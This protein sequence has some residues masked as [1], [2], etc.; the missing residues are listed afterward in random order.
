MN[1]V[2]TAVLLAGMT[3]LF[4]GVGYSLGGQGG[5]LI[6]LLFA[7]ATNLWAWWGSDKAVLRMHGA[8]PVLPGDHYGLYEMVDLLSKNAGLPTPKV[9]LMNTD[10]PNAFATGRN[11][12][13]AAVAVTAGL[14]RT[15]NKE[16]VAGVVAH[17]LA[18]VQNRDTLIMTITATIAGAVSMIARFGMMFGGRGDSQ[19]SNPI[20][21]ILTMIAAPLAAMI[22]QMFVSRT[23]EYAADRRGAEICGNPLWL[24]SALQGISRGVQQRPM[25]SAENDPA[26]A[27]MFIINPL[28]GARLDN[29]FSTHP[30]TENRVAELEKMAGAMGA[31]LAPRGREFGRGGAS[32]GAQGG[33][34]G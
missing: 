31:R 33:P 30:R 22:I 9:Y 7:A 5:M 26:T 18:H 23:R 28:S 15:L 4:M 3:A 6:A 11:P 25:I 1:Y 21:L 13:N 20:A 16:E 17:E 2:K 8:Q 19:R 27:P 29:L 34:W 10:Q 24:A 14:L 32:G 12:E